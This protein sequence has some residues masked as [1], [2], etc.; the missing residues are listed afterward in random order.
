M[1][2]SKCCHVNESRFGTC[3]NCGLPFEWDE[4]VLSKETLNELLKLAQED[5]DF[6]AK[7]QQIVS[8]KVQIKL[9]QMLAEKDY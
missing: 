9:L 5:V 7:H 6:G 8:T 3:A 4:T 2:K 1:K